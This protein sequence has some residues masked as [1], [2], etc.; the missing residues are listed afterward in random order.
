MNTFRYA[1]RV[2]ASNVRARTAQSALTALIVGL[3]VALSVAIVVLADA[4]QRGIIRAADAFGV[5]VIG[6]KGS[7]QQLVLNTILLQD[8]PI[9][10]LD[11]AVYDDLVAR[12]PNLRIAPIAMGD[13][14]NGY[15]II[16]T[17]HTFFELRRSIN[18][19]PAFQTA[20]GRLFEANF[21]AVLGAEAAQALGLQIGDQFLTSHGISSG[22]ASD[23]H[24]DHPYTVVGILGRANAPHD[25]GVF[26]TLESVWE[27]HELGAQSAFV[28]RPRADNQTAVRGRLTAALVLP[29]GVALNDVYRIAQQVNTSPEAQA[30][31]PGA[32][33]G[34]LFS[35]LNQGQAILNVVAGLALIM[36]S[37]TILLSLY[38]TT[39]ARQ[40]AIAIMRSLGARRTTVFTI[41]LLEAFWLTALGVLIGF[42]LGH[43]V[44]AAVSAALAAQSAIPLQ[45]R[46]VWAQELP[47]LIIP[48]VL[49]IAA[50]ILPSVLAYRLNVVEKLYNT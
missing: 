9:G 1:L 23:V 27:A 48:L 15:P 6:P 14:I 16:G 22:L 30:A 36:A 32:Q 12:Q 11:S 39:L 29:F 24:T 40:Q 17:N 43:G 41:T 46:I 21:E 28:A 37:L 34:A 25:R 42:A 49:G 47:L 4:A 26:V 5:L 18:E 13:N 50:G 44:A 10:L 45:T 2:A 35:Q 19:P 20:Q 33:L 8:S 3:A 38:S 31:F 7:A